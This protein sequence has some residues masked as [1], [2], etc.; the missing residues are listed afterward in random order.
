MVSQTQHIDTIV[1]GGGQSGLAMSYLLTRQGKDHIVLEKANRIG[2][3]WRNRWDSFTL[4]TPNWQLQLPGYPYDGDDPDGF[5]SR[6]EVVAYLEGYAASFNPPVEF[7]CKVTAVEKNQSGEGYRV[8]TDEETYTCANVVVAAGTFQKPRIPECSSNA[9]NEF[10][11]I[12]SSEYRNPDSLPDGGVL[13]VGSG[14]SGT[15]IARELHESGREVCL[16]VSNV[17]R[18]P[19]R[20]RG[21]DGMWWGVQIGMTDQT[22]DD[23]D[24]R[25]ERFA[26]N[27]QIS[28]K[29]GGQE[30]NLHEFARDGI[31]LAG[32]LEDIDGRRAGFAQNL[33]EN[34]AA[35]DQMAAQFR[36]GVDKYIRETGM[37][38]PE[39][40]VNEPQDGFQ[41]EEIPELDLRKVG[42][43]TVLWATGYRWDYSW[44]D[45]PVFDE[46]GYPVQKRGV[47]GYPGLYFLGL[48]WLHKLKSGLFLGVGEDAEHVAGHLANRRE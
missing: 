18:L 5:L 7:G 45:L 8:Y 34:L 11:Q 27:P 6:E 44:I 39:E 23:L 47:T 12:H 40:T 35:A 42:I 22:V 21:K 48:H 25:E 17:G 13:V 1:I 3:S 24:S 20:Y 16:S 46:Y 38:L 30:I 28:G 15:Q 33:H 43:T 41:Q 4:V 32:Y 2:E 10:T 26:P 37:D 14:Q 36:K 31:R 29:D 19:R 9:E